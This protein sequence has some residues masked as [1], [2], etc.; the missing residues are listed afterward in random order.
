MLPTMR[1]A[2]VTV[3]TLVFV[4]CHGGTDRRIVDEY[5]WDPHGD[6]YQYVIDSMAVP[7]DA[8]DLSRYGLDLDWDD[9]QRPDNQLGR[10]LV[11]L[12]DASADLDFQ[13]AISAGIARGT[14]ITLIDIQTTDITMATG[15]ATWFYAGA[16]P[17]VAPCSSALDT[18]CAHHLDGQ[19]FFYVPDGAPTESLVVGNVLGGQLAA[20]PG[21][22]DITLPLL[23][24]AEPIALHLTGARIEVMTGPD[25]LPLGVLSGAFTG[26]DLLVVAATLLRT[27][28]DVACTGAP[29]AETPCGCPAGDIAELIAR[30]APRCEL[31]TAPLTYADLEGTLL[32]PDLDLIDSDNGTFFPRQDDIKDSLSFGIGFT[33]VGAEFVPPSPCPP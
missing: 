15:V 2:V 16:N 28:L 4:A 8:S 21:T 18:E 9:Q 1:P 14:A 10:L 30:A 29:T 11:T 23:P 26:D 22:V 5:G 7:R 24:Y 12:A 3:L 17:S 6:H 32:A 19:A 33:A 25:E 20:G 13:A 31:D 27:V